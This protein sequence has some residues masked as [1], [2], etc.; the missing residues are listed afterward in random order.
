MKRTDETHGSHSGSEDF[1]IGYLL[2]ETSLTPEQARQLVEKFGTDRET[3][4]REARKL[5]P[6][7]RV[8]AG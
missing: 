3:L 7:V 2:A 1:E 6:I 5:S 8:E 4:E